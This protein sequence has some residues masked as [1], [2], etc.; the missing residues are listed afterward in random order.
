MLQNKQERIT[1]SMYMTQAALEYLIAILMSGSFLAAL[2]KQLGISDS[3]TGI[4]SS[5]ISLGCLFQLLSLMIRKKRFKPFI[6]AMSVANQILFLL[7]YLI[8]LMPFSSE[9]KIAAF[10]LC[11]ITAYLIYNLA[12]PKKVDW[13]LS[14]IHDHERGQFSANKE[15]ISLI[16]G[17]I[18]SYTMGTV[19]DHFTET[20]QMQKSLLI[21]AGIV[22]VLIVLH[23][24]S[25]T[26]IVEIPHPKENNK[27]LTQY[28]IDVF[29]NRKVMLVTVVIIL[30]N[31]A[32]Y[33]ATP[34]YG[35]YLIGELQFSLQFVSILSIIGSIVRMFVSKFWGRYADKNSFSV[36]VEKCFL[37]LGIGLIAAACATPATGIVMFCV[38]YICQG[39]AMGGINSSLINLVFDYAEPDK[40]ADSYA[41]CSAFSGLCGF[42]STLAM[43]SLV[44]HIQ[45]SGNRFLGLPL[46]AQQVASVISILFLASAILFNRFKIMKK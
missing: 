7:L 14:L 15:I 31:I 26:M 30:Y 10:V 42:L 22:M 12:H 21:T 5:I 2:T 35:T 23:T 27:K 4:L 9:F 13:T 33:A 34:F 46:Y 17:M 20:G 29:Q 8:P 37:I 1:R 36:M 25:M 16:V 43:S 32:T 40:R 38:Y 11:I 24:I 18:F 45:A 28:F 6:I 19:I 3:L 44:A 39:I 41:V